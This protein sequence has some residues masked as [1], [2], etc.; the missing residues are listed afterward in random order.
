[1]G[2]SPPGYTTKIPKLC[3]G[4]MRH[5]RWIFSGVLREE[6]RCVWIRLPSK[7][8]SIMKKN[9]CKWTIMSNKRQF[10]VLVIFQALKI[11]WVENYAEIRQHRT[12]HEWATAR[13][14]RCS[15]RSAFI[16]SCMV[17]KTTIR[18]CDSC[19][20]QDNNRYQTSARY[21][22]NR[23][24]QRPVSHQ[25]NR[26]GLMPTQEK[27]FDTANLAFHFWREPPRHSCKMGKSDSHG[28]HYKRKISGW[29]WLSRR[30]PLPRT[31]KPHKDCMEKMTQAI[32][33]LVSFETGV[34]ITLLMIKVQK[35]MQNRETHA[36]L[37]CVVNTSGTQVYTL[38]MCDDRRE[39]GPP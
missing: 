34:W 23:E 35:F 27:C 8:R 9:Q 12:W 21:A 38:W 2:E 1:M 18:L 22:E 15:D 25:M 29:K 39:W 30:Q 31:W 28:K 33:V 36:S 6:D 13:D 14:C 5:T 26:L 19:S 37:L 10:F 7:M 20:I 17:V 3:V 4:K 24:V 32:Y 11:A 16:E